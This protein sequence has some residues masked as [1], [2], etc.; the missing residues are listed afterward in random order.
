MG[1]GSKSV[2]ARED[3]AEIWNASSADELVLEAAI[4]F[5]TEVSLIVARGA[6]GDMKTFPVCENMHK[7][8]ILDI[9]VTAGTCKTERWKRKRRDRL[10]HNGKARFGGST[11]GGDVPEKRWRTA[12]ERAGAPAT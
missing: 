9:T 5:E 10:R 7:D 6:D 3:F 4:D 1:K 12:G 2:N 8:H 11:C